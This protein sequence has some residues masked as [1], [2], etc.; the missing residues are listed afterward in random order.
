[1]R[2]YEIM[3]LVHPDHSDQVPAMIERYTQ[4]IQSQKGIIHRLENL[5]RRELAY[6]INK[7]K[8]A[9]YILTNIECDDKLRRELEENFSFNDSIIRNLLLKQNRAITEPS[10]LSVA[11]QALRTQLKEQES[12]AAQALSEAANSENAASDTDSETSSDKEASHQSNV[13]ILRYNPY[14]KRKYC[15]FTSIKAQSIDYKDVDLLSNYKTE[16]QKISPRRTTGIRPRYQRMLAQAFQR[17]RLVG[18]LPYC[19][20]YDQPNIR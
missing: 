2:H 7:L 13:P 4:L 8:K 19:D 14:R 20:K 11:G 17:A 6:P 5:E 16:T 15:Y 9:H 12:A 18:L 3:L 10:I 1:M